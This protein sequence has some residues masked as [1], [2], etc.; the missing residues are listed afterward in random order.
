LSIIT[1]IRYQ[2][3]P[4]YSFVPHSLFIPSFFTFPVEVDFR[5]RAG[6][7]GQSFTCIEFASKHSL[8]IPSFL[9][10][11]QS[12]LLARAIAQAALGSISRAVNR[13]LPLL[14]KLTLH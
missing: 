7:V 3:L 10:Y 13:Y 6:G 9:R 11:D 1:C 8:F 14:S 12:W 4:R 5:H 2:S